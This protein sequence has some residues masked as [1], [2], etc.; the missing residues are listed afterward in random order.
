MCLTVTS[1][2]SSIRGYEE[3]AKLAFATQLDIEGKT[4][5]AITT[6]ESINNLS[7]IWYLAQVSQVLLPITLLFS[8]SFELLKLF[9]L[10]LSSQSETVFYFFRDLKIK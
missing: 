7:A 8:L 3:E 1:Q 2:I 5:D 6:L 9:C 10:D 4:E